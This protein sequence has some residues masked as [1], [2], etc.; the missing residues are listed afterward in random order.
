LDD[1]DGRTRRCGSHPLDGIGLEVGDVVQEISNAVPR[2]DLAEHLSDAPGIVVERRP[3]KANVFAG[4]DPKQSSGSPHP[5]PIGLLIRH[6]VVEQV[7]C[8]RTA[9]GD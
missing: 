5:K 2:Y 3:K 1:R 7:H 9:E 6:P 8:G 4:P